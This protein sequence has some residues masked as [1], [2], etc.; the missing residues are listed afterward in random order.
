MGCGNHRVVFYLIQ[1]YSLN[2][3]IF[4]VGLKIVHDKAFHPLKNI[5]ELFFSLNSLRKVPSRAIE[6]LS[7][8]RL[9]DLSFNNIDHISNNSF[10]HLANLQTLLLNK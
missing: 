3:Y 6:S 7:N 5:I 1:F 8:L 10:R 2:N 9:L 4:L